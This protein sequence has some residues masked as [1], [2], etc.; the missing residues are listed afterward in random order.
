[1]RAVDRYVI[2]RE[3]ERAG[4][5]IVEQQSFGASYARILAEWRRRFLTRWPEV[6][7]LAFDAKFK[8]MWD[9]YL[10]IVSL[11]A[12][13]AK[14]VLRRAH[15][16]ARWAGGQDRWSCDPHRP[17]LALAGEVEGTSARRLLRIRREE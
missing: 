3:A 5:C 6:E 16:I 15:E 14:S 4:L 2:R 17:A 9:F 8:R 12:A 7:R 1:L 11:R 10:S 13:F